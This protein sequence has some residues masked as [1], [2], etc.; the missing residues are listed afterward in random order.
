VWGSIGVN[1]NI[2]AASWEALVDS[3]AYA[4]QPGRSRRSQP[5]PTDAA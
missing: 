4:E 5:A 2:I 3:L 1:E